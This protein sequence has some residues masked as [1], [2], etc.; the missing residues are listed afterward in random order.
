M[1]EQISASR[2]VVGRLVE[3]AIRVMVKV[4]TVSLIVRSRITEPSGVWLL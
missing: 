2:V 3:P 4:V 1:L